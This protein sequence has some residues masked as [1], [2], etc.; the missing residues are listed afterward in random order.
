MINEAPN[1][2][3]LGAGKVYF[4]QFKDEDPLNAMGLRYLGSTSEFNLTSE[5]ET[6]Q[7]QNSEGG[8]RHVDM[9][10]PLSTTITG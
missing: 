8:M 1:N 7:H 3:V 2:Y 5:T 6:L 4:N 10:V 9:E